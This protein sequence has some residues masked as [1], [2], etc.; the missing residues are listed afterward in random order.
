MAL[1][2]PLLTAEERQRQYDNLAKVRE[3]YQQA[4]KTYEA[5]PKAPEQKKLLQDL[6]KLTQ[7]WKKENEKFFQLSK[8]LDQ[9]GILNPQGL[10]ET[11]EAIKVGHLEVRH[12]CLSLIY[13]HKTFEGGDNPT[14]CKLGKWLREFQPSKPELKAA[15]EQIRPAHTRF[16]EAVKQ[17]KQLAGQGD[18]KGAEAVYL[19]EL[20]P[21][22]DEV[23]RQ[24]NSILEMAARPEKYTKR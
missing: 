6:T 18:H 5:L 8:E 7:D 20:R 21:A 15:M 17:I 23:S 2:N 10:L 3:D 12:E 16:H 22:G 14:G 9:G 13:T 19:N 4:F 11:L 24:I 1:V